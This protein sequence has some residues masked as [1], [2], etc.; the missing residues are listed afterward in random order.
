MI[1]SVNDSVEGRSGAAVSS[2]R[3]LAPVGASTPERLVALL[4]ISSLDYGGA[5]RQA[6]ELLNAADPRQLDVHI[7][8]LS[9]HVPL[10]AELRDREQRLH[11]ITKRFRFDASVVIRLAR[12]LRRLRVD[13]VQSYLFDADIA[14][15][16][17]GRLAHTRL[18]VGTE[19]NAGYRLK[20]RRRLAYL[21]TR[22]CVDL[23]VANS[24]AGAAFN[25]RVLGQPPSFYRVVHNGVDT[26]RFRPGDGLAARRTLR[27]GANERIVG[28]FAS[29]KRQKNH[30]LF[31]ATAKRLL[32]RD[33]DMRFLLVG[34]VLHGGSEGSTDY[35]TRMRRLMKELGI[36]RQCIC[37][38]HRRDVAAL[39]RACDV[40]V[41]PSL[42]EGTPNA[43]LESLACAVP[44]VATDVSDNKLII[45]EG[46]GGLVVRLGDEGAFAEAVWRLL[47]DEGLRKQMGRNDWVKSNYLQRA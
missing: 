2:Q 25:S 12:L 40:T 20:L 37:V 6:V 7:C 46:R 39:Y 33:P 35:K 27:L 18:V 1:V 10:A 15:R 26:D 32:V 5:Q 42:F 41:I 19:R 38:G 36:E 17:A 9:S 24:R 16:L 23:I 3:A 43:A 45:T 21:A 44:V 22:G 31:F 30:A 14:V 28:M 29:F 8:S 11:V 4:V 34:D 47:C 13:V